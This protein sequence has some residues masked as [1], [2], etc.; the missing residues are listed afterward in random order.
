MDRL[1]QE[2]EVFRLEVQLDALREQTLLYRVGLIFGMVGLFLV[3][4]EAGLL[5]MT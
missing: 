2:R 4:R 5:G 3:V 1:L